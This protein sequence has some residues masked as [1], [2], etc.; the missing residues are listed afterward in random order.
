M[1]VLE[2]TESLLKLEHLE[3]GYNSQKQSLI[4]VILTK[5]V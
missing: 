2:H 5:I 4:A 1:D 3:I